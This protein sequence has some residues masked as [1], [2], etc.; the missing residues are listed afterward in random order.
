MVPPRY[1]LSP[2]FCMGDEWGRFVPVV[3][4]IKT[5]R[6]KTDIFTKIM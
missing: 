5:Q 3:Y 1:T 4:E 2:A 6:V